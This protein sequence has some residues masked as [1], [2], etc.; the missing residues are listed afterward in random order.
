M[1][2]GD[3]G[4]DNP[5]TGADPKGE[6]KGSVVLPD[7]KDENE[8]GEVERPERGRAGWGSLVVQR[9]LF[10]AIV[11]EADSVLIDEAITPA[12]IGADA[13]HA[14]GEHIA[15][16]AD[17]VA[18][19]LRADEHYTVDRRNRTVELTVGGREAIAAACRDFGPFWSGP[20][21][22][23]EVVRRAISAHALH[24]RDDDYVVLDGEV[25]I[26]D[27]STGRLLRGRQWQQGLHQ[28]VEAKEGVS[29]S[30][31]RRTI[32]RMSYQ[33]FFAQYQRLAGMSGTLWEARH[34]LWRVYGLAVARIPTHKPVERVRAKD[35]VFAD[36]PAKLRAAAARVEAVHTTGRPVL[37]GTRSV[38]T[39]EKLAQSL[40]ERGVRC[41]V[42]NA[43]REAEEAEI[44]AA[45]GSRGAVT[46]ATNMAG[47]GTDIMLDGP[48]R[49]L[50]GLVVVATERHDETRVDRQLFGRAGRQGDPGA[51]ECFVSLD[52]ALIDRHGLRP[53]VRLV[54][55]GADRASG[56]VTSGWA[57]AAA[58]ALWWQAQR[59]ASS[60]SRVLR[61]ELALADSKGELAS[62]VETR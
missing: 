21:R 55:A 45:A 23:E 37:V 14:D 40:I 52:D 44:I 30:K 53:L 29:S 17:A 27:R 39:S 33:R 26:V 59:V 42:L 25:V 5:V 34:E 31:D 19:V 18:R 22:R 57:R 9:G 8:H 41:G 6:R 16:K 46:V 49:E 47:R 3:D 10:S 13:E 12:I 32:A 48:S 1:A 50:G 54:R 43:H 24:E 51:A 60:S 15:G 35:R 7:G 20:R 28:A 36:E 62:G 4:I 11:D 58:A 61:A 56:E 2:A 38:A